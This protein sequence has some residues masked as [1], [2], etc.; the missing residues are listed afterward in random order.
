MKFEVTHIFLLV[1]E[2]GEDIASVIGAFSTHALAERALEHL[3][4]QRAR[5][6]NLEGGKVQGGALAI[7][8]HE[9]NVFFAN[10]PTPA[11]DEEE[12]KLTLHEEYH[13]LR[14]DIQWQRKVWDRAFKEMNETIRKLHLD[15]SGAR[16]LMEMRHANTTYAL[17][18]L[19]RDVD[20]LTPPM[21]HLDSRT[22]QPYGR[23]CK[24]EEDDGK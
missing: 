2:Y 11:P 18:N 15:I 24:E 8:Q 9:I 1:D 10:A 16:H 17:D 14:Y 4:R 23:V 21:H 19:R 3:V 5:V 13:S 12:P 6:A 7:Q 22:D 20:S